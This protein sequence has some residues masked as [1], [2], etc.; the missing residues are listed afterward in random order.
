MR[1][2][3]CITDLS[4]EKAMVKSRHIIMCQWAIK[5]HST[6]CLVSLKLLG[7]FLA[8]FLT[9]RSI[10]IYM[11]LRVKFERNWVSNELKLHA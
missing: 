2:T 4:K 11:T 1:K 8:N 6:V 10:Y 7:L 5:M 3:N 9:L